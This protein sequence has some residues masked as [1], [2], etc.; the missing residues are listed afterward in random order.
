VFHSNT[1]W[2]N[3]HESTPVGLYSGGGYVTVDAEDPAD[4]ANFRTLQQYNYAYDERVKSFATDN[5]IDATLMTG[6]IQHKLLL[7]VDYRNVRNVANYTFGFGGT[8]DAFDPVYSRAAAQYL[9]FGTR[10]NQQRLKQTGVYGQDQ[11]AIGHLYLLASGRYDWINA[12]SAMN[13]FAPVSSDPDFGDQKQHKFTYHLGANYVT[14]AGIAPYI[15]YST[16]FEPVLGTDI[17]TNRAFKPTSTK[18]W[19]G[20]VKMDARGLPKDV[21][22]FATAALFD[23]KQKNFVTAQNGQTN[24]VGSTQGGLVEVWGGEVELVARI[25]EQLSINASYSYNHSEVKSSPNAAGDIGFPLPTTPKHK[26]SLF[27]DYTFQQGMLAGFG[28]GGGVRYNSKSAGGL[29]STTYPQLVAGQPIF[30]GQATLFDAILHYDLPHW[31]IAVNGSNI[32]DKKYVARC[33]G[34]YGC[35]YGAGRQVIGTVTYKF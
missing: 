23:I 14:D 27:T 17:V 30:T 2:S 34:T 3:Y 19:E 35:V 16:S 18:Q 26:L 8:L 33:S 1:K 11:I 25:H 31:R 9:D 5:R 29:P 28:L 24:V 7:G 21:K 12:R 32:L 10:Y 22:L 6:S 20:G 15:S 13:V 4:P